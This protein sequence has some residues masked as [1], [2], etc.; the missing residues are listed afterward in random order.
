MREVLS[1][2]PSSCP[3]S[4]GHHLNK[5]PTVSGDYWAVSA[6]VTNSFKGQTRIINHSEVNTAC[7]TTLIPATSLFI[8]M[9]GAYRKAKTCFHQTQLVKFNGA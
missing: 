4:S 3:T 2:H 9:I 1:P 8:K 6:V 7:I 5:T